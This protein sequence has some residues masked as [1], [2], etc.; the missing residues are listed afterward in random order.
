MYPYIHAHAHTQTYKCTAA[1]TRTLMPIHDT[2]AHTS[3]VHIH[4][5]ATIHIQ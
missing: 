1:H 4:A 2:C 3:H 5:H